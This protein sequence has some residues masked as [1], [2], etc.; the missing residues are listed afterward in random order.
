MKAAILIEQNKPLIV[1]DVIPS[2]LGVGQVLVRI[3]VSGICGRQIGEITG[4]KGMDK[5][6][7]HLLGHE[8]GGIIEKIGPGVRTLKRGNKVVCHWRKGLGIE[9][10]FPIYKWKKKVVGGG[11]VTTFCELAIISE[12]RL[13][14]VDNDIP[15]EVAALMGCATTTALGLVN[16]EAKL[17]IG[18]SVAIIGCGS[19][20]LNLIQACL[21]VSAYPIIAV[22]KFETKLNIARD[23]GATH[24]I[25]TL[26][27]D[28]DDG[29]N[30]IIGSNGIDV[31]IDTTGNVELINKGYNSVGSNGK[32]IMVGQPH[33]KKSLI[34]EN[35]ANNFNGKKLLDSVGGRTNPSLDIPR[36]LNLYKHGLLDLEKIITNRYSLKDINKAVDDILKGKVVGKAMIFMNNS[37]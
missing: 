5:Y 12:N 36:Y 7:P 31:V 24:F 20:G 30:K 17:K 3:M 25:N 6:I 35:I 2:N 18:Q 1:D 13:T 32:V 28:L 29:I 16:N 19:V 14:K 15:F 22:D 10:D 34:L 26:N 8:G 4:S 27:C 23:F 11:L 33:Y 37:E 21:L 9:S